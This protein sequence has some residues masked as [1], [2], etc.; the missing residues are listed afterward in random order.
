MSAN[1]VQQRCSDGGDEIFEDSIIFLLRTEG[2]CAFP[3]ILG[4]RDYFGEM[5]LVW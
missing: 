4:A 2:V 3:T 5:C 1:S